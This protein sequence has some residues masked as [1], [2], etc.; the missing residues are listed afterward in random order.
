MASWKYA[1]LVFVSVAQQPISGLDYSLLRL[2]DQTQ[3]DHTRTHTHTHTHT[4][5]PGRTPLNEWSARITDHSLRNT[6]Q[7]PETNI[8][9]VKGIRTRD[10]NNQATADVRLIQHGHRYRLAAFQ[11]RRAAAEI[12]FLFI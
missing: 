10:P 9:V 2:L 11:R 1:G 5:T 4:H 3:L 8:H 6:Q 12:Y 7:T